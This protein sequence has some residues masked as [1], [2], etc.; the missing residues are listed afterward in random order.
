MASLAGM[1]LSAGYTV[2]GSDNGIYPPMSDVLR[3]LGIEVMEG[4]RP[5]NLRSRPDLVVVGNVIRRDNPEAVELE[6]CGIAFTSMPMAVKTYFARDTT[7]IVVAGTHGKTTVSSMI[8]WIL[9]KE[10]LDPGFMI[11]GVTENFRANYR[12]GGGRF[13]VIEGDE[14]DTAYF[15]KRAKFLHYC[16]HV[17]VVTSCE[18]DHADIYRD[19][20]QIEEQFR[21]FVGSIPPDGRLVLYGGDPMVTELARSSS[22]ECL[23]YGF[24]QGLGWTATEVKDTGNGIETTILKHGSEVSSGTLPV[25]GSHNVLNALAAVAAV[26]CVGVTPEGALAAL[27]S[28]RGVKRR[29]EMVGEA[30]GVMVIDDFAHHPTAVRET[31]AGVRSRYPEARLVAVFEPGTNTSKRALFQEAYVSAFDRADLVVV[32]VPRKVEK[33]PPADRFSSLRLASDLKTRGKEAEAF[34]DTDGILEHLGTVLAPGDVVLIMSNGS[35]DNL[36]T[37]LLQMLGER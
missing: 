4:Y 8:A 5:A 6:K 22:A 1:F 37:R 35:F 14:Y 20:S 23:S 16:P 34:E 2:T 11:G 27:S 19:L 32:R 12:L 30:A 33:I 7:R 3:E 28:F 18:F 9:Y 29:Q 25:V 24:A 17:G 13:F 36:G 15:D 26:D 31:C 10:G 21:S